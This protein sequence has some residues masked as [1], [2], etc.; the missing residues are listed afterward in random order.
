MNRRTKVDI[1]T[2]Y[3]SKEQF[4]KKCHISKKTALKLITSGLIPVSKGPTGY[5]IAKKDVD[6]YLIDRERDPKKYGYRGPLNGATR[7]RM[8][9]KVPLAISQ[10]FRDK[11]DTFSV[12]EV[13]DLFGCHSNTVR[14]WENDFG[15]SCFRLQGKLYITKEAILN[16]IGSLDFKKIIPGETELWQIINQVRAKNRR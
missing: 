14:K 11:P 13:A 8:P 1:Q 10:F 3:F 4:Y 15:L 16:F 5:L 12:Q 6:Q 9:P 7:K 2:I